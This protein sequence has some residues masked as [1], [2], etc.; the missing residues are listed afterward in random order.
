MIF[1]RIFSV[2]SGCSYLCVKLRQLFFIKV[3]LGVD[4]SFVTELKHKNRQSADFLVCIVFCPSISTSFYSHNDRLFFNS[5]LSL[6]NRQHLV[7]T[8][9]L[10]HSLK[11]PVCPQNQEQHLFIKGLK[12]AQQ[13]HTICN[14]YCSNTIFKC[15]TGSANA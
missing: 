15:V 8:L 9:R 11:M 13:I 4:T 12:S 14:Y 5:K 10:C 7:L 6:N 1:S 2:H 3:S